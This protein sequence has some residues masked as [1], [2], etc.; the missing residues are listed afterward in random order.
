MQYPWTQ[1][2]FQRMSPIKRTALPRLITTA[3]VSPVLAEHS[4]SSTEGAVQVWD[5]G[6]TASVSSVKVTC[7]PKQYLVLGWLDSCLLTRDQD[8]EWEGELPNIPISS[9]TFQLWDS[10]SPWPPV[11][12]WLPDL[13]SLGWLDLVAIDM[14][15]VTVNWNSRSSHMN[16]VQ[17]P[18]QKWKK[19]TWLVLATSLSHWLGLHLWHRRGSLADMG[20][21]PTWVKVVTNLLQPLDFGSL[22]MGVICH[23]SLLPNQI[24]RIL[25]LCIKPTR[26]CQNVT[27]CTGTIGELVGSHTKAAI[28]PITQSTAK[29]YDPCLLQSRGW[30]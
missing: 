22:R 28:Y 18:W 30:K 15:V 26:G 14:V 19:N 9:G 2:L 17:K 11:W 25:P 10:M 20:M 6:G 3:L 7:I 24:F 12:R 16:G 29:G 23:S 8:G 1:A 21:P 27:G 4:I 5:S 13:W